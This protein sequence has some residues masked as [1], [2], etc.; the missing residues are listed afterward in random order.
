MRAGL[1][2][3]F[4]VGLPWTFAR[5]RFTVVFEIPCLAAS[6]TA[7]ARGSDPGVPCDA[8]TPFDDAAADLQTEYTVNG[9]R[10]ADALERRI[11]L[12]L[13]PVFGGRTM[14][15]ITT[16][17]IRRYI[18]ERQRDGYSN[19]T[20]N[21]ELAALK[22]MFS[23]ARKG[24]RLLAEHVPHIALLREDNVRRGFFEPDAFAAVCRHLPAALQPMVQFAYLTGW[25][26]KS[27]VL[28]LEWRQVDW[29]GRVVRLEPGVAKNRDGRHTDSDLPPLVAVSLPRCRRARPYPP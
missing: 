3:G 26:V 16:S 19:A 5:A 13:Q 22:R 28:P 23:L 7:F 20:I 17:D 24:R 1:G 27:E 11:R 21:R 8:A 12:G 4:D 14:M 2:V 6:V 15:S 9:R 29:R 18:D 10:S 25:R